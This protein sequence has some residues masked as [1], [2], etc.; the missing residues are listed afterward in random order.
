MIET[1][2]TYLTYYIAFYLE[3]INLKNLTKTKY[4]VKIIHL[5]YILVIAI[6][7]YYL[8]KY[9]L[10]KMIFSFVGLIFMSHKML[11]LDGKK[12]VV[13]SSIYYLLIVLIEYLF[14]IIVVDVLKYNPNNYLI[15]V[16][17]QK[18]ILGNLLSILYH[19]PI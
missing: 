17:I 18:N 7:N 11:K 8:T 16:S 4:K 6:L 15:S 14:S 13:V 3:L 9:V 2:F 5:L 19:P 1:I 10:I 12:S